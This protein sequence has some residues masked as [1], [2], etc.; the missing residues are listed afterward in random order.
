MVNLAHGFWPISNGQL[1]TPV[2]LENKAFSQI[3]LHEMA[4]FSIAAK[5]QIEENP[6]RL[7]FYCTMKSFNF[8]KIQAYHP[9]KNKKLIE[10]YF[11]VPYIELTLFLS[12]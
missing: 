8:Y 2:K 7:I 4:F 6:I 12:I 5:Q 11:S 3:R 1:M 9:Y 10:K